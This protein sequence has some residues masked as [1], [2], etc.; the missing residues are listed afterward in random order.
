VKTIPLGRI[1]TLAGVGL[2][3]LRALA[4][5][6]LLHPARKDDRGT[7]FYYE[8]EVDRVRLLFDLLSAGASVKELQA[9]DGAMRAAPTAGDASGAL[10]G[11]IDKIVIRATERIERLREL[12]EDLVRTRETLYR[13]HS[14]PRPPED[15][16]CRTCLTM[17]AHPPRVLDAFFL[18]LDDDKDS[19]A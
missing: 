13:C 15:A 8:T 10:L 1:A 17:P 12:R 18:V 5:A 14:C 7:F 2:L 19:D 6:G 4:R 3:E 16:K 11:V 9:L